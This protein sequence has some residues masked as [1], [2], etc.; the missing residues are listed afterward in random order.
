V[1]ERKH[2]AFING[3]AS[4]ADN[5][6]QREI[7]PPEPLVPV[8]GTPMAVGRAFT[9]GENVTMAVDTETQTG[10]AADVP[11]VDGAGIVVGHDGS[12]G[13]DQALAEA[14]VLAR[15]LG[16]PVVV[17]RAW[18]IATAP[19]P[20]D[21]EFGYVPPFDEYAEAVRLTL[22]DDVQSAVNSFE[23]VSVDC[24]EVHA[25]AAKALIEI[26]QDARLLVVGARGLG[27]LAGLLLGSVSEQCVRHA[28]CPV[29]VT[30]TRD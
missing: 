27:G 2:A 18:S 9:T 12:R 1:V 20:A 8:T 4:D 11:P 24:Q 14:L 29:L 3:R 7:E 10:S 23:D 26:S 15:A 17:V 30:R 6:S 13:A 16:A 19:R 21:W 28:E 22:I 25:P 5:A